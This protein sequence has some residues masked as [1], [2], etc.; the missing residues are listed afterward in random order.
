VL[1]ARADGAQPHELV[2]RLARVE[3]SDDGGEA[4]ATVGGVELLETEGIDP[5]AVRARIEER[6][7][8]LRA[9]VKRGEGKLANE[10]FVA[11]APA[12]VVDEERQKLEAYR[13]ELEELGE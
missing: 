10:G 2:S 4:I 7:E 5:D 1:G 3:F 11:K 13:A 9:E 12:D 6:R 8:K